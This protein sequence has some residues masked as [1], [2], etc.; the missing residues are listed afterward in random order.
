MEEK[1]EKV[2]EMLG[3]SDT[4]DEII[5]T[6]WSLLADQLNLVMPEDF[7]SAEDGIEQEAI[8][9]G[10]DINEILIRSLDESRIDILLAQSNSGS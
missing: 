8:N 6:A 2:L 3:K 10:V 9:T 1:Q 7:A 4:P 5:T